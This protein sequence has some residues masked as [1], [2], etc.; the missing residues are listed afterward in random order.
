MADIIKEHLIELRPEH[1]NLYQDNFEELKENLAALDETFK[2]TLK[3]NENKEVIVSHAAYG[4]WE[5]RYDINQR[6]IS[7]LSPSEEPS[8]NN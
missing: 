7:G 5:K 4:Y 8:Q 1:E 3:E 6:P 2:E